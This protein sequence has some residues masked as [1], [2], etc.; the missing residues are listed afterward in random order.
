MI[1]MFIEKDINRFN[2]WI[3]Y[4]LA[5][6]LFIESLDATIIL[7][8]L[9][10]M[11]SDL[12][13]NPLMLK[14]AITGYLLSVA[15]FI[16]MSSWLTQRFGPR[17]VFLWALGL[18]LLGSLICGM[19]PNLVILTAGRIIQG[20]G[21]AMMSPV[22]MSVILN[23]VPK[24]G[25]SHV[26]S[27][28]TIP[29]SIGPMLG[30]LFGGIIVTYF[31]WR[32]IFFV[33][34]PIG[35]MGM[36]FASI[37]IPDA[38]KDQKASFDWGGFILLSLGIL[39]LLGIIESLGTSFMEYKLELVMMTLC[40]GF[41][42]LYVHHA[43]KRPFALIPLDLFK[44]PIFSRVA[45]TQVLF[46]TAFGGLGLITPMFLQLALQVSPLVAGR[47]LMLTGL[48]MIISKPC[49]S[50]AIRCLGLPK[51]MIINFMS[52]FFLLVLLS[53]VSKE[54]P[55]WVIACI[56][57]L[58][59]GSVSILF[60]NIIYLLY[61]DVPESLSRYATSVGGLLTKLSFCTGVALTAVLLSM[62][63]HQEG[64]FDVAAF[65]HVYMCLAIQ[66]GVA[67]WVIKKVF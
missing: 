43:H 32:W 53:M 6:A 39:C 47:L 13:V 38:V 46:A 16:P 60:M 48:A 50:P 64:S 8:A 20:L 56:L 41:F 31:S 28:A 36:V 3:P 44:H 22:A 58:Q 30:P 19:A 65:K 4:I 9:P 61:R 37:I 29:S 35:L 34:I 40:V 42:G 15:L 62:L 63:T 49:N 10:S 54:T 5:I 14:F 66:V 2:R 67:L 23:I 7:T 11:A 18:F 59:G 57:F 33:N 1:F 25:L 51:W 24:A 26:L 27:W 45:I 17:P 21:G 55:L 52:T 12:H